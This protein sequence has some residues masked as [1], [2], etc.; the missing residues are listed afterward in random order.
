MRTFSFDL[1]VLWKEI[2][3]K[4]N[5]ESEKKEYWIKDDFLKSYVEASI[6]WKWESQPTIK[7]WG[8]AK[9]RGNDF[10]ENKV[11]PLI[12]KQF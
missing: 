11:F 1:E 7:F 8:P 6:L 5:K 3:E 4:K 9:M 2:G 12:F 10:E